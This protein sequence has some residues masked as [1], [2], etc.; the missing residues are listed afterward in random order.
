MVI[1]YDGGFP[2]TYQMANFEASFSITSSA[3]GKL[4]TVSDTSAYIVNDQG[5]TI[6]DFLSRIVT[7]LDSAGTLVATI[8]LGTE[9]TVTYVIEADIWANATLTLTGLD[10]VATYTKNL[11]FPFDR[12]T[13]NLYR[14][15]L[16]EN[17]CGCTNKQADYAL[18][19]GDIFFRGVEIAAPAGEGIEWQSNLD[20]AY[21]FLDAVH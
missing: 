20:S 5:L 10:L 4:L 2:K 6:A 9:L 13:K 14:E 18:M 8:D 16:A 1:S 19:K 3:D 12:I 15:V 21:K 7:I 17:G 11:I